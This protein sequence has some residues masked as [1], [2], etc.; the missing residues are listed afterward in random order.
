[1][2]TL[3]VVAHPDKNSFTHAVAAEINKAITTSADH[4]VEMADLVAEHFDPRYELADHTL[5]TRRT[6]VPAD[7][8][9][10]QQ[11][12]DRA[13]AL[14]LVYPVYWWSFP[15]IL[16]GW[17]DRVFTNGWAYDDNAQ[18]KVVKKLG[19]LKVHLVAIGGAD[20]RTYARH[21][22]FGAM[23]TQI[24]H[25]IFDYVGAN[26]VTSELLLV[27]EAGFPASQLAVAQR[28]GNNIATA[29]QSPAEDDACQTPPEP[30]PVSA[31][32]YHE[33]HDFPS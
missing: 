10:E 26:V 16:K 21:G 28:I 33:K 30:A 9:A 18:G 32:A 6:P 7:V 31:I 2:H 19:R 12:I 4:S 15:G 3:I 5:F 14:V 11:R 25:G 1:M 8:I 29:K 24:D 17:I 22:Y 23:K 20:L 27:P 13:E